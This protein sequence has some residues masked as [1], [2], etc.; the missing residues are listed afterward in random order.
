M[1]VDNEIVGSIDKGLMVLVGVCID[2]TKKDMEY[3]ARKIV[4]LRFLMMRKV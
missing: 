3:I 1:S 2:D 4:N